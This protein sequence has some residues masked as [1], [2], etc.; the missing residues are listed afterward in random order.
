MNHPHSL[1]RSYVPLTWE[2]RII[3]SHRGF[4]GDNCTACGV[5]IIL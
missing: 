1:S 5:R 3:N 4:I 2:E